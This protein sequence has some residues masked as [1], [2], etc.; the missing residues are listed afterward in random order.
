MFGLSIVVKIIIRE[1]ERERERESKHIKF[2]LHRLI[3]L[4]L[5]NDKLAVFHIYP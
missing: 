2:S 4:L 5:F 1:R 3:D